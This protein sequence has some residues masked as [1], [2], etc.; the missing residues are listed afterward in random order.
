VDVIF[1]AEP[2]PASTFPS[3]GAFESLSSEF[4]QSC[5]DWLST[6]AH[7]A[8][9]VAFGSAVLL[10][11]PDRET[12]YRRLASYLPF[13]PDPTAYDF[14]YQI[15]RRRESTV[16]PKLTVNRLS[17]WSV[18]QFQGFAVGLPAGPYVV[19]DPSHACR[20]ELDIN[21]ANRE[22]GARI[23]ADCASDLLRELASFARDIIQQG[24]RP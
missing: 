12:G 1:A 22:E 15:N 21:N 8:L 6:H 20:I 2:A 17:R 19:G 9:R 13:A 4:V 11:V 16:L 10:P 14:L 5:C 23:P 7:G 3:I 24:D 18:A